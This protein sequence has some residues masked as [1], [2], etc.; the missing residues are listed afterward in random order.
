MSLPARKNEFAKRKESAFKI[1]QDEG[2]LK[3]LY[4]KSRGIIF[5]AIDSY[6][7]TTG[8]DTMSVF[9]YRA[10]DREYLKLALASSIRHD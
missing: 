5:D 7:T 2:E 4:D 9:K 8:K 6:A 3:A 10:F 1:L